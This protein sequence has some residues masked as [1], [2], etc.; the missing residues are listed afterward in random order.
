MGEHSEKRNA[1][2]ENGLRKIRIA[3]KSLFRAAPLCHVD[4]TRVVL[5]TQH[6]QQQPANYKISKRGHVYS[7]GKFSFR[8]VRCQIELFHRGGL[9]VNAG[10]ETS[11]QTK[12]ALRNHLTVHG[13][14]L[15]DLLDLLCGSSLVL[16]CNGRRP[17]LDIRTE[18]FN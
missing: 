18:V 4:Q 12:T 6:Y 8:L 16:L 14:F 7:R 15:I 11:K 9:C 3:V 17:V 1:T 5:E 10:E 13:L 2:K